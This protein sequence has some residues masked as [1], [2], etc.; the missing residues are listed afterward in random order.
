[1]Y[2]LVTTPLHVFQVDTET[3]SAKI[4]RSGD[5]Y[6]YGVSCKQDKMVLTHSGGY[7]QYFSNQ[8]NH[9]RTI[10]TLIQP[11]Q[12]EWVGDK[13][14]VTNTGKNRL[15]IFD[16]DG[17]YCSDIFLNEIHWDDKDG[18]RKGN[19]FNSVHKIGDK[20]YIVSHNYDR[21]S[22]LYV[23]SWP[24]LNVLEVIP[25]KVI[26]AHNFWPCEWGNLVCDS[27]HGS[28]FDITKGS[29]IWKSDE[30][31][32]IPRGLAATDDF[33]IVGTSEFCSRAERPW[34]SGKI[35]IV[36]RKTLRTL[37]S[38]LLPGSGE[39][40]DIRVIGAIDECHNGHIITHDHIASISKT[41]P[42]IGLAYW[43][44]KKSPKLRRD[45]PPISIPVRAMQYLGRL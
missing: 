37:D 38:I 41:S 29:V 35:W 26:G 36:D 24:E 9:V 6:Y 44:R 19:H 31:F 28:L 30:R 18:D 4:V 5:G 8:G 45:F 13:V 42:L 2:L 25:C 16:S 40:R 14:V 20:L 7:L 1:M 15:A 21:S 11:H 3:V 43:L 33:I 23:L 32:I 27:N 39:I 10:N 12:V 34:S 22:E 17:N